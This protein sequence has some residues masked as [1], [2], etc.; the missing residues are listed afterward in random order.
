MVIE[1]NH[2]YD[3]TAMAAPTPPPPVPTRKRSAAA[4]NQVKQSI[5]LRPLLPADSSAPIVYTHSDPAAAEGHGQQV[6]SQTI[7]SGHHNQP[8]AIGPPIPPQY[9]LGDTEYGDVITEVHVY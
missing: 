4:P 5:T 2:H 6:T 7:F 9:Y 3:Q 8:L 1:S